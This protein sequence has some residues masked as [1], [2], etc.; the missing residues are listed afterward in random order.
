MK[1]YN[2]LTDEEVKL[3]TKEQVIEYSTHGI[4]GDGVG[5]YTPSWFIR[6]CR[7]HPCFK[8]KG[9]KKGQRKFLANENNANSGRKGGGVVDGFWD[10]WNYVIDNVTLTCREGVVYNLVHGD[11]GLFLEDRAFINRWEELTGEY[12]YD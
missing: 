5:I 12:I 8:V 2:K 9:F 3:L 11:G 1:N 4:I 10:E 7:N 6:Y